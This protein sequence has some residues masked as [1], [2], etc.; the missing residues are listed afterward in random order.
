MRFPEDSA[1]SPVDDV[2]AWVVVASIVLAA[3]WMI[4]CPMGG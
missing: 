4:F 2:I 3:A 1:D